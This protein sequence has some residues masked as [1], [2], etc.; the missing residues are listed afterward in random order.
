MAAHRT[1]VQKLGMDIWN[2]I[3][4]CASVEKDVY[5]LAQEFFSKLSE[6]PEAKEQ[7]DF[8][9]MRFIF[10]P[11]GG[12]TFTVEIKNGQI[13][14]TKSAPEYDFTRDMRFETT[15]EVLRDIFE[16]RKGMGIAWRRGDVYIY[17]FKCKYQGFAWMM[18]LMR[19]GQGRLYENFNAY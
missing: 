19:I 10:V 16:R 2:V 6:V 8:C 11:K 14:L 13:T 7:L 9:D 18:R 12:E 3:S 15:N 5:T 4:M 1:T 17:G